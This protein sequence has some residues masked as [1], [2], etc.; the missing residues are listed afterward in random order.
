VSGFAFGRTVTLTARTRAGLD[1]DGNDV[2]ADAQ[3][4][5]DG[6]VIWP[7]SSTETL[8]AQD[9]VIVGL[10]LWL[11]AG[12][13]IS[14]TDRVTIDGLTYEVEGEPGTFGPSPF[15]GTTAGILVALTRV[16][17]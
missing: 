15:T 14:A 17:A 12:T 5:V 10:S 4:T 13:A 8:N 1:A 16:A 11:P 2:F 7:R 9:T 3:R 6:C